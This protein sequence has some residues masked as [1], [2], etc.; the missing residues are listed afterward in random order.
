MRKTENGFTI[1]ETIV[2][3]ILLGFISIMALSTIG[4]SSNKIFDAR[5]LSIDASRT[6]SDME[7]LKVQFETLLAENTTDGA[8]TKAF[9][10]AIKKQK[11]ENVTANTVTL[12]VA[13]KK[14]SCLLVTV[15]HDKATLSR[16]FCD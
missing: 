7:K 2:G 1:L 8:A 11:P 9:T 3:I 6:R 5:D 10:Q 14:I 15:T 16:L 12:T 13:D 4:G